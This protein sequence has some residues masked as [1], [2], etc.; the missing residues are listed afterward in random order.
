MEMGDF[1]DRDGKGNIIMDSRKMPIT[2]VY[3]L[4]IWKGPDAPHSV[5][6][7]SDSITQRIIRIE[8]K[9]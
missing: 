4:T 8:I 9:N 1:I 6:N 3:P 7:L 5:E 2:P